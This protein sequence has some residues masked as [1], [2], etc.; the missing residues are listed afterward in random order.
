MILRAKR[1]VIIG[2]TSGIGFAVAEAALREHADVVV[3]SSKTENVEAAIKRLSDGAKGFAVNVRNEEEVADFFARLGSFDHLVFTAGDWGGAMSGGPLAEANLADAGQTFAI[4]FW[5]ALACVKH[6]HRHIS[7]S[8]S[9]TLTDG[10]IAHRPR[11]G[12]AVSSA[13]A[14]AIEHLVGG[15]A[16]ELAPVRVNAVCPGYVRTEVWNSIPEDKRDERFRRMTERLPLPRIGEPSEIAEAY[17]YLMRGGYT[18]GQVL[19]IDGGM[20]LV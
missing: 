3:V 18:T 2:G 1:A 20:G 6:A 14:G 12:A 15:L 17:L 19:H 10:M 13:M 8:G 4:R 9:I 11:K 5:G 16:L 7:A